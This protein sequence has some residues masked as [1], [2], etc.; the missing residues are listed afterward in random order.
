MSYLLFGKFDSLHIRSAALSGRCYTSPNATGLDPTNTA[1]E[2]PDDNIRANSRLRSAR[3]L[4]RRRNPAL[5]ESVNY[6]DQRFVA[7]V[8]RV[9]LGLYKRLRYW[10]SLR[11]SND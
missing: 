9:P 7:L 11:W 5:S 4:H 10:I 8:C 2:A 1:L 3:D 6:C